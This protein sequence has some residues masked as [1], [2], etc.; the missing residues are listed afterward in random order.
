MAEDSIDRSRRGAAD[1]ASAN[2]EPTCVPAVEPEILELVDAYLSS[3]SGGRERLVPLLQRIQRQLGCL[4]FAVQQ[5]VARRLQLAPIQVCEVVSFYAAFTTRPRPR[6]RVK[7]CTGATC[8]SSGA[9]RVLETLHRSLGVE[10]GAAS[11]DRLFSL[12]E[13]DCLGACGLA[14]VVAVNEEIHGR[15]VPAGARRLAC[16]LIASSSRDPSE[17]QDA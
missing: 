4:P 7:A 3:A 8:V 10:I 17:G 15:L 1:A 9:A 16:W 12:E 11:R 5:H 13:A 2:P 14:P 6:Y